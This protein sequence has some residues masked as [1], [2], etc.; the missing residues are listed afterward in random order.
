MSM[1][2]VCGA[3]SAGVLRDVVRRAVV[4]FSWTGVLGGGVMVKY[5]R[6]QRRCAVLVGVA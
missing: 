4:M 3:G 1:C 5:T 2:G 6:E